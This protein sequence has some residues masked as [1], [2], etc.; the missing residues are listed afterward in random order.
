M[1][2]LQTR[3]QPWEMKGW[4]RIS[5]SLLLKPQCI[6]YA[7]NCCFDLRFQCSFQGAL[8]RAHQGTHCIDT[9]QAHWRGAEGFEGENASF[10]STGQARLH[11]LGMQQLCSLPVR[12]GLSSHLT[13]IPNPLCGLTSAQQTMILRK[14]LCN[15]YLAHP[16]QAELKPCLQAG[17]TVQ[18]EESSGTGSA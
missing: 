15:L 6:V 4:L 7:R 16:G 9:A 3:G 1:V 5:F 10:I 11:F 8:H 13:S 2:K 12:R 18:G 17:S 14:F